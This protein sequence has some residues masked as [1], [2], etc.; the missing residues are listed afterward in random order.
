MRQIYNDDKFQSFIHI[1]QFFYV[2]FVVRV[3]ANVPLNLHPIL[4]FASFISCSLVMGSVRA[5]VLVVQLWIHTY[6]RYIIL[7]IMV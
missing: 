5:D 3:M 4:T 2:N 1:Y 7:Y 6:I